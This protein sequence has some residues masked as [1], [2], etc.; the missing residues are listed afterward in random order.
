[1]QSQG[2]DQVNNG[3]S[4]M[5]KVVQQNASNAEET[6]SAAEELTS[7]ARE[8]ENVVNRLNALIEGRAQNGHVQKT[9]AQPKTKERPKQ[10]RIGA[11]QQNK[12][13][14]GNGHQSRQKA[15][16][17]SRGDQGGGLSQRP[18][19]NQ[20][21]SNQTPQAGNKQQSPEEVIPL[22]DNDFKDF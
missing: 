1:E 8:L 16:S 9:D 17:G 10:N 14:R 15:K 18:R 11:S 12:A 5:D 13:S 7:E 19:T 21:Q 2:I 6:A 22:D 3:V 20:G 4:E